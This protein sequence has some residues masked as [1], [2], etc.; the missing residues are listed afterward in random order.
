MIRPRSQVNIPAESRRTA[1]HHA[2]PFLPSESSE[3]QLALIS[4]FPSATSAK[5]FAC[6]AVNIRDQTQRTQSR[7]QR[8]QRNKYTGTLTLTIPACAQPLASP[9]PPL[10]L[11]RG[12]RASPCAVTNESA[13][14]AGNPGALDHAEPAAPED[15]RTPPK[16]RLPLDEQTRERRRPVLIFPF[17]AFFDYPALAS[18][19][20]VAALKILNCSAWRAGSAR[21]ESFPKYRFS[22]S[23]SSFSSS[24]RSRS[25]MLGWTTMRS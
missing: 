10:C 24:V 13:H 22:I 6:S 25:R 23:M 2:P 3:L 19:S 9:S 15:R 20:F 1:R 11:F 16:T 21:K 7:S 18:S 4:F 14:S 17:G 5:G 12:V 8:S